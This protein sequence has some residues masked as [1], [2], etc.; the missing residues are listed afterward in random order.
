MP[1]MPLL[2]ILPLDRLLIHEQYD[3]QRANPLILKIRSSRIFRNP[4]VVT[5]LNDGTDRYMVLDGANRVTALRHLGIQHVLAQVVEPDDPGLTLFNWNH[6]VWEL[7]TLRFIQGIQQIPGI[8][9][10]Y[11]RDHQAQAS[12]VGD[13]RLA[14][15]QDCRGRLNSVCTPVESLELRVRILNEIVRSYQ[16]KARLDRTNFRD[17]S[18]LEDIYPTLAGLVIFPT[19]EIA[20]LLL[21]AGRA[22]LLPAGITRFSIAPRAL[23]LDYPLSELAADKSIE[24]KNQSLEKWIRE[25]VSLKRVRYYAEPTYLFDE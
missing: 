4:P 20:D 25:R 7:D 16:D 17:V 3:E 2:S 24:E 12:L 18:L 8:Q 21:L 23:H 1:E 5:P 19:F 15:V 10:V 22:C 13:C 11:E 6:V 9:L 14:L